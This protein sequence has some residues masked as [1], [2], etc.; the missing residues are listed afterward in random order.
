M[1][2]KRQA[3]VLIHLDSG[4]NRLTERQTKRTTERLT[5]RLK[6]RLRERLG[7]RLRQRSRKILTVR[8]REAKNIEFF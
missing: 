2:S 3:L 6:E 7:E 5:E 8:L 1:T 4:P